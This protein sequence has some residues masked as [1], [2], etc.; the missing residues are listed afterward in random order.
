MV[1]IKD[2]AAASGF[3][4][5]T[6]SLVLND[7]PS[8]RRISQPTRSHIWQVANRLGY[9]PNL[10]A[11][12]LR[13]N[14]SQTVGV[15]VF[16][17]TDPYCAQILRAI[18]IGLGPSGYFPI[19]IDLQNDELNFR[20]SL[21]AL[22][23]RR[24]EGI[25]AIANPTYLDTGL[26]SEFA[27]R[28][29]PAVVIGRNLKG[30]PIS[31]V[32]PDNHKGARQAFRHLHELGHTKIAFIR[33]PEAMADSIERWQGFESYAQEA[34][35]ALDPR[36]ILELKGRNSTSLEAYTLTEKLVKRGIEF[37]ALLG[38]D[39]LTACAAIR[40]LTKA[41]LRVPTDCSVV[42]F[43]DIPSSAFYNPSLTTV[44]QQLDRQGTRGAEIIQE[45]IT[46]RLEARTLVP[47]HEKLEPTVFVRDSSAAAPVKY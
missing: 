14:R 15:V 22:Q 33:G 23:S 9:N 10:F 34:G 11:R 35:V 46:A 21:D 31:S 18:E 26:F 43:D 2:V 29:L 27:R 39:D 37:T 40:A 30:S 4:N 32:A 38:F 47:K 1:T 42:G 8:A 25:I 36:L 7:R 41:G 6:V 3:S 19:L 24:V 45:L 16:D 5:T 17:I 44:Q 20:R 13:S 12:S 28:G